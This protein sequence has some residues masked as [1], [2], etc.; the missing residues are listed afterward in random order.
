MT[1]S[2]TSGNSSTLSDHSAKMPKMTSASIV[3]TVTVGRLMARSERN[4]DL[5]SVGVVGRPG[6]RGRGAVLHHH[7]GARRDGAR[8]A[9]QH[10]VA[11]GDAGD[12]LDLLAVGVGDAELD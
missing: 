9:E 5:S 3:T 6:G 8:G 10:D 4:I 7:L 12:H 2:A 11:G 1:G